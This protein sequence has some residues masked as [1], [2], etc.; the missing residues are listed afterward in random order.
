VNIGAFEM[1][2]GWEMH[3]TLNEI[4][5]TQGANKG[6]KKLVQGNV[7]EGGDDH[8]KA[9]TAKDIDKVLKKYAK[10]YKQG[11]KMH[12]TSN[13][14]ENS[15]AGTEFDRMGDGH[16]A[17]AVLTATFDGMPLIYSG[18]EAAMDKMLEFFKKDDIPWG[19]FVYADFYKTLLGLKHRN[20]ALWNGEF[21]G[22]L[23]KIPSGNDDHIY[24]FT[25]EK[26]GDKVVVIINLSA[27]QQEATLTGD[28]FAG[29]YTNVF[30]NSELTLTSGESMTMDAWD[31]LVLE[32]SGK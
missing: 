15:W 2:Y 29:A 10:N 5:K 19:E 27:E 23:V 25:R 26:N 22:E 12:F 6:G 3:H 8:S 30:D 16:K 31:Y 28:N 20:E 17:F 18:Q 14:D 24:A 32:Q 13:H 9:T 21:G 7:V 11:Y 1:D 4:A